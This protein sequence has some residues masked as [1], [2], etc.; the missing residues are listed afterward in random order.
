MIARAHRVVPG[1]AARIA[2]LVALAAALSAPAALGAPLVGFVEDWPG[3]SLGS[4]GGGAELTNPGTGGWGGADDGFLLVSTPF[5]AHLGTMSPG[6]E[7]AGDWIAAEVDKIHVWLNDVNAAEALEIH[8]AIGN[9]ANF[10]EYNE[11]FVPPHNAWK[12]F[13]VDL[14]SS[15]A[16][17]RIIGQGTFQAALQRVDR[18][19]LRHD[20]APFIQS[21]DYIQGDLGIDRLLLTNDAVPVQPLSW[22]RLKSLYR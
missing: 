15:A 12:E 4:W 10:W 2:L 21:P 13:V 8:F 14:T 17:T 16:F 5:P 19:H 20:L 7:Y 9:G 18:I 22:G 3:I 6:P 1:P 11:G